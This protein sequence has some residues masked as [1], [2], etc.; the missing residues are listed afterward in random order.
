MSSRLS[1]VLSDDLKSALDRVTEES[2]QPAAET[3]SKALM[4]YLTARES[5]RSGERKLGFYNAETLEIDG[6][7]VGL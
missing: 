5:T 4:L 1:I 7:V 2:E 6:E 3:L